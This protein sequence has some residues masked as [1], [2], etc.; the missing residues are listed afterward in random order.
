MVVIRLKE[1]CVKSLSVQE[2]VEG[3]WAGGKKIQ[4]ISIDLKVLLAIDGDA[5]NFVHL[6][7]ICLGIGLLFGGNP[8]WMDTGGRRAADELSFSQR[9]S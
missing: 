7:H 9:G 4:A 8:A 3:V 6:G 5:V 2:N 1:L